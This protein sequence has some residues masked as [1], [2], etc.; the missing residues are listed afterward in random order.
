MKKL[1]NK[2]KSFFSKVNI[3]SKSV[4]VLLIVVILAI[5]GT[6]IYESFAFFEIS[7]RDS[8]LGSIQKI[9]SQNH[10]IGITYYGQIYT[11]N[12]S[13]TSTSISDNYQKLT[14]TLTNGWDLRG[15][16]LNKT[17][18]YCTGDASIVDYDKYVDGEALTSLMSIT[19]D[20]KGSCYVY[21]DVNQS[22][23]PNVFHLREGSNTSDTS[24]FP[25][26]SNLST[27]THVN[28]NVGIMQMT[29]Y[30]CF[31]GGSKHT[32]D[33]NPMNIDIKNNR[34][35]M[36][37]NLTNTYCTINYSLDRNGT[38]IDKEYNSNFA[39]FGYAGNREEV[40]LTS[41]QLIKDTFTIENNG[42][43]IPNSHFGER[44]HFVGNT[45]ESATDINADS[46]NNWISFNN[47]LWRII[48]WD[49]VDIDYDEDGKLDY[50]N[51]LMKIYNPNE[52]KDFYND[53]F[54]YLADSAMEKSYIETDVAEYFNN[55][56]INS[57]YDKMIA[58]VGWKET[59]ID[60]DDAYIDEFVSAEYQA[61]PIIYKVG[62]PSAIDWY[63]SH[64]INDNYA[65]FMYGGTQT[66]HDIYI[67]DMPIYLFSYIAN[68]HI[69]SEASIL[70]SGLVADDG[71]YTFS[72]V[73][74]PGIIYINHA[75]SLYEFIS[76]AL[77]LKESVRIETD[78]NGNFTHTGTKEDPYVLVY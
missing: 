51:F 8:L 31:S 56:Y 17:K 60:I 63:L 14:E 18:T 7:T 16:T 41:P 77:Y 54:N 6:V 26:L 1:F 28:N 78:N 69:S 33:S 71:V 50:S 11:Y 40:N 65:R 30:E 35:D 15:Y 5:I 55:G 3:K 48:G 47:Q 59:I 22:S 72:Q 53:G 32:Q 44:F 20:G 43:Q 9:V 10:D 4:F 12:A 64:P 29:S 2:I 25:A 27:D 68:G 38:L 61:M 45:N 66:W 19:A 46:V 58:S 42:I 75:L 13:G 62:L 73:C 37:A 52:N 23:L 57:Q 67:Y 36:D 74:S 76:P 34:I 21:L 24:K 39:S 70:L 49:Y